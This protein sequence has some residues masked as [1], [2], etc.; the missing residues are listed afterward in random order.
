MM[1]IL[2]IIL[3]LI[4]LTGCITN[5]PNYIE[6]VPEAQRVIEAVLFMGFGAAVGIQIYEYAVGNW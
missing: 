4:T 2:I 1:R 6:P 5:Q 3:I